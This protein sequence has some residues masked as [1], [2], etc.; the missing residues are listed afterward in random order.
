MSSYSATDATVDVS[1]K[2]LLSLIASC[3]K[4][5]LKQRKIMSIKQG[6]YLSRFKGRGMEFDESRPY[7]PGDDVRYLDWHVTART[8]KPYSKVFCEEQERPVFFC[9]DQRSCM[10]FATRGKFKSVIAAELASLL[11]WST[12]ANDRIGSIVFSDHSHH[13]IKP[14]RGRSAVLRLIHQLVNYSQLA[15]ESGASEVCS[16]SNVVQRLRYLV[17]PGSLIFLLSDF[18]HFDEAAELQLR[19]LARHNDVTLM[20]IYDPF[21]AQLPPAG[22]YQIIHA[23]KRMMLSTHNRQLAKDYEERFVAHKKRLQDLSHLFRTPFFSCQTTEDPI[24]IL[25]HQLT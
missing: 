5:D 15:E 17:K 7:Q 1:V 24:A 19:N 4:F 3:K 13:E 22:E 12:P 2:S 11:A 6:D 23:K 18:R 14:K 16:I 21:E 25:Q 8:G 10:R 9:V 20:L